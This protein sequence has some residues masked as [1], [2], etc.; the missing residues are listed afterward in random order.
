M[1]CGKFELV[2]HLGFTYLHKCDWFM[3]IL[4]FTV[5]CTYLYTICHLLWYCL[6]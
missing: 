4:Q 6:F 3:Q 1:H 2:Y 5:K